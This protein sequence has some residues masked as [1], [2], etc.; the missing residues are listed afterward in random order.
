MSSL[1]EALAWF[2]F[3]EVE[4]L[5]VESLKRQF[6]RTIIQHHPDR[7]GSESDFDETIRMY[8]FLSAV[9]RQKHCSQENGTFLDLPT[10]IQ[11][12][13]K[14]CMEE[15][16]I[17]LN[18][19]LD[20][21]D[22]GFLIAFNEEFEKK[23]EL[24]FQSPG[25]DEWFRNYP[26]M[27]KRYET[28]MENLER[29][30]QERQTDQE[31]FIPCNPLRVKEHEME[32]EKIK[33]LQQEEED[34]KKKKKEEFLPPPPSMESFH[35]QFESSLSQTKKESSS[36]ILYPA[37]MAFLDGHMSLGTELI[38]STPYHYGSEAFMN[39][40]YSDLH[41]AYTSENTVFDKIPSMEKSTT[42]TL[43]EIQQERDHVYDPITD[44]EAE[45]L[46]IYAQKMKEKE[47]MI[48]KKNELYF[49]EKGSSYWALKPDVKSLDQKEEK[50]EETPIRHQMSGEDIVQ[51][52][53]RDMNR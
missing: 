12:R 8:E 41:S 44:R 7:G 35:S 27:V 52:I 5:T 24:S 16:N 42:R 21:M 23:E 10:V 1:E 53:L 20:E 15:L 17:L 39:P 38:A 45:A 48:H 46:E 9:M 49:K 33:R 25:Y 43:D 40:E 32:M 50:E 31:I 47:D 3:T 29:L 14:Q 6:K 11:Q 34:A 28:L 22:Q 4:Q 30:K 26:F 36:L 2:D 19:A 51:C 13:E 18:N 37:Q